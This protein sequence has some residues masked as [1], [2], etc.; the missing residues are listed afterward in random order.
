V[1]PVCAHRA[2]R[3]S[4]DAIHFDSCQ[5]F[6]LVIVTTRRNVY[7]LIVLQGDK[8]DVLVR[9]GSSFPEFCRVRLVG[10][11]AGGSTVHMNTIDVGLRMEFQAGHTIVVTTPVQ[12]FSRRSVASTD[13][14]VLAPSD[15]DNDRYA[16]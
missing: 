4:A 2:R 10:S 12:A 16:H 13:H 6:E 5:R 15:V 14:P 7:E 1:V 11:T 3:G 9:G 8:G